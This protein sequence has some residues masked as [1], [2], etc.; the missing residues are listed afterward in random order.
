[1]SAYGYENA[2]REWQSYEISSG[3]DL[4]A[5]LETFAIR[6]SFN[7]GKIENDG[8]SYRD[9]HEIFEK[10]RVIDYTGD[11]KTLY[12]I[13]NLKDAH[14]LMCR[15]F[16]DKKP[17][18]ESMVREM[19]RTIAKGTYDDR[20][21][22]LGERPGSYKVNDIWG[23]G[24]DELAA[25]LDSIAAEIEE[26]LSQVREAIMDGGDPLTIAAWWHCRF[27]GIHAFADGNGRTGRAL[28]NYLLVLQDMPPVI[29]FEEDRQDYYYALDLFD[30][31]GDPAA[32]V[33]FL[34]GQCEKTW[35]KK[36]PVRNQ[37]LTR[38]LELRHGQK[39][40][41]PHRSR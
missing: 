9:T 4:R 18:D 36:S 30:K 15:W 29:V 39:E 14:E 33:R 16:E 17:L 38:A 35:K 31:T 34:K 7:S 26:D 27:E 19:H 40:D 6:F 25:P 24:P 28:M 21:W 8:I 12:E 10:G 2:V 32:M 20:R 41:V 3:S 23:V 13:S 5:R 22:E 11:L 37:S 1:M